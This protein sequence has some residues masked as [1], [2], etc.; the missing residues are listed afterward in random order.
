MSE[1]ISCQHELPRAGSK[2]DVV[3][4]GRGQYRAKMVK[5][6]RS[7]LRAWETAMGETFGMLPSD[8]WRRVN[9]K[10]RD[11]GVAGSV[12]NGLA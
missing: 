5:L 6:E 4:T 10:P 11:G 8:K 7:Q 1:W 12:R 3:I 9:P 2:V